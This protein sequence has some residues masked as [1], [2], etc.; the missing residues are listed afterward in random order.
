[1]FALTQLSRHLYENQSWEGAL[2]SA[3]LVLALWWLW[4]YT[5]WVTNW[6]DPA[7]LPVRGVVLGLSLVG[8]VV[9][10]SIYESFGDRGNN[11]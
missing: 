1:M 10:V 11:T 2:E 8:F 3:M 7:K 6:L 4:V 5:T 9:S